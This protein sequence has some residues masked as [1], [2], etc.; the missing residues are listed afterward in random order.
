MPTLRNTFPHSFLGLLGLFLALLTISGP[1]LAAAGPDVSGQRITGRPVRIMPVGDS[2][3]EGGASFSNW[4]ESLLERLYTAGYWIEYTGSR[5]SSSRW[6]PLAHEGYGGKNSAFLRR[7]VPMNFSKQ[8]ADIVLLHAGHNHFADQHPVPGIVRDTEAMIA[9]FR[10]TN[11]RVIVLLAQPIPSAKLPK[12]SY[13]PELHGALAELATRLDS[14]VSPVKIVP[15]ARGFDPKNDTVADQVHPNASGA[16][17]MTDSWFDAITAALGKPPRPPYSPEIITYKKNPAGDLKLH[18][19]RPQGSASSPRPALLFFFGGGWQKGT[20]L[21]F[22]SECEWFARQGWVAIS[23]DYRTK[24]SHHTSPF[25]AVA[26]A[27][28]ALRYLRS[29]AAE[30]G[31]HPDAIAAAGASAGG[32]LAAAT[33]F[34][35]GLDDPADDLS[36]SCKPQQLVLWYPVLDNGPGGYGGAEVK[37]RHQEFSPYHNVG[38]APP[39]TLLFLGSRDPYLP[40]ARAREFVS[41]VTAQGGPARLEVFPDAGH[42]IYPWQSPTAPE[43]ECIRNMA[44]DFLRTNHRKGP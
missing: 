13:L 8:P 27:K 11:P 40:V 4:R 18:V 44:L 12:Y 7:T 23:A 15:M 30:L 14:P 10:A 28:S 34:L 1:H 22:Y 43:R 19:F 3:T 33:A 31:I 38:A 16:A 42:P 25:E 37:A 9:E 5:K 20:P 26:D 41:K 29:H 6:G 36:I 21:Q 39:P 24:T 17:K 32:H 2:I 35:P